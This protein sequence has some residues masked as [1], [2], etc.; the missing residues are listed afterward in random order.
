MAVLV[1]AAGLLG[2]GFAALSNALALV[3]RQEESL[4]GAVT[5]LQLPLTFLSTAFMQPALM[6]DWIGDGRDVQPG[7]LGDPRRPRGASRRARTG[8][9][10]R[11]TA[12]CCAGFAL[13]CLLLATRAFRSYQAQV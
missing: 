9:R 8:R 10:S 5:F 4:I 11:A 3:T 12:A 6:P 1:L 13:A 2:T 7:R